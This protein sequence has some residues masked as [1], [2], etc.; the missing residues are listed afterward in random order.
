MILA[1]KTDA[2]TDGEQQSEV[3]EYGVSGGRH[4]CPVQQVRLPEAQQQSRD[5]QHGNG[6]H[7]GPTEL[8]E[9]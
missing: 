5:G 8:L 1:R 6:Q 9:S 4:R 7:Q 2:D 3:R